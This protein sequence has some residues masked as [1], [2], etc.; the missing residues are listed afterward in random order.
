MNTPLV[1]G[2]VGVIA[3]ILAIFIIK[4]MFIF[5]IHGV[6]G[7]FALMGWNMFFDPVRINIISVAVV[8]IGGIFGLAGIVILHYLG[9]YF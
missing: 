5:A 7:L 2:I 6:I 3:V 1:I 8:A 9:I 4:R